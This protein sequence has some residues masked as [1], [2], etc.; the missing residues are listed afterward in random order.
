MNEKEVRWHYLQGR[1]LAIFIVFVV[2][3][4]TLLSHAIL[5]SIEITEVL[6]NDRKDQSEDQTASLLLDALSGY[7]I[8]PVIDIHVPHD[9]SNPTPAI[10]PQGSEKEKK[11]KVAVREPRR[12]ARPRAGLPA[13]YQD[14]LI[15]C[16]Y[17]DRIKYTGNRKESRKAGRK[18]EKNHNHP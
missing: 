13:R 8:A 14:Q 4:L 3:S 15:S 9:E 16:N 1:N 11:K 5:N 7:D 10:Q 12:S 2:T 6:N 17:P 18:Q